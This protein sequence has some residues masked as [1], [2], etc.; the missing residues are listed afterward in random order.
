[1]QNY[2][3]DNRRFNFTMVENELLENKDLDTYEKLLYI[4]LCKFAG[5]E[6]TCFPGRKTLAKLVSCGVKTIDRRLKSLVKKGLIEKHERCNN[7][8]ESTSNLYVIKGVASQSRQGGVTESPPSVTE[9]PELYS[10]NN[11]QSNKIEE[12]DAHENK[13]EFNEKTTNKIISKYE[14]VFGRKLSAEFYQRLISICS[15]PNIIY[16]ALLVAEEKAD[17]PGW[18]IETLKNWKEENL[19]SVKSINIHLE[20]ENWKDKKKYIRSRTS[21]EK[22]EELDIEKLQK[23]G[24]NQ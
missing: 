19:K 22:T 11:I 3:K 4:V 21:N 9:S 5:N 13:K 2:I 23:R 24:W 8:G 12:E 15:D 16:K 1:M 6:Q 20:K 18:L 14:Q 17:K 7:K 10:L